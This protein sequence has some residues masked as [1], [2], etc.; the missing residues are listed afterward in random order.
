MAHGRHDPMISI[1]L[2]QRSVTQL[3]SLGYKVEWH[4]YP[5]PHSVCAEEITAIAHWLDKVLA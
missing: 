3:E 1:G 5:M 4:E 2:A